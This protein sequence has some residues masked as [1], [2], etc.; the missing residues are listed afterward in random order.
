M[1][2][3]D[4][5]IFI[6]IFFCIIIN[7]YNDIL[8]Y[9]N[10]ISEITLKI[11][12]NG[13]Q[14]ILYT[15]YSRKPDKIYLNGNSII[16]NSKNPYKTIN[17]QGNADQINTIVLIWNNFQGYLDNI[18]KDLSNIIEAD[19]SKLKVSIKIMANSF[20]GC[21]SLKFANISNLDISQ[22]TNMGHLFADCN[23]LISVDLSNLNTLN[24]NY[25]DNMFLN[26][27]SLKSLDLSNFDTSKVNR[28]SNMFKNCTSLISL[29]ISNFYLPSFK[30]ISDMFIDCKNLEYLNIKNIKISQNQ[31][32]TIIKNTG[33]NIVICINENLNINLT[34]LDN[35]ITIDC[36]LNWKE[37]QKKLFV[38]NNSCVDNCLYLYEDKCYN[39]CPYGTISNG[40]ICINN[41]FITETT[42]PYKET[43]IIIKNNNSENIIC[44]VIEFFKG[45]CKINLMTAENKEAFKQSILSAI[46]D[47]SLI[48]LISSQVNNNSH[49]VINDEN[50]IYLIS[51]LSEQMYIENITNINFSECENILKND[52]DN[53]EILY[54]FR[55]DHKI[56]GYNIPIIEYVIFNENGTILN[57]DKCNNIYSQYFIP[58]SIN[59]DNLFKYDT[60]SDYYNDECS[61]YKSENGTDMT[62]YDRKNDY[63]K[64]N[65]SLCEANCTFKGYNSSTSKVECECKTKS[66]LYTIDD[67]SKDDLLN[68]IENE[69]KLTNLNLIKCSN[70]LSSVDNIKNN[71]GFYIISI[72][73]ILFI[74]IMI[75]FCIKGYKNLEKIIDEV[76]SNKFKPERNSNKSRS[77]IKEINLNKNNKK[78]KT[79]TERRKNT[80][81]S[82]SKNSQNS[83]F[84]KNDNNNNESYSKRNKK[85]MSFKVDKNEKNNN[86]ED[87]SMK[88]NDYELNNL[89]Y[90]LALKQDK[91]EFCDYYFSLIKTKQIIFFSFCNFDD[92]NSDII[93]K[94][95]FF[96][97][98]A[99]HYTINA[100]FFT[101]KI[102]HKL[103]VVQGKFDIIYH[104]PFI[105]Y[106]AIIS[107]II[108]RIILTTLVLTEKSI[109]EVKNQMSKLSALKKKKKVL[110]SEK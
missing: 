8:F 82:L 90:E 45:K 66:Y 6:I 24:V 3:I 21:Y 53:N 16:E 83:F 54:I 34:I 42:I 11:K 4:C 32:Q 15:G 69:Q 101:D 36:S 85:L 48:N 57:L 72:I 35:C 84:N 27:F 60:S 97:S 5:I 41:S 39:E 105:A 7:S 43:S 88:F 49:L 33:I 51:S 89:S 17:I 19:L 22:V 99:L 64:N 68:K 2:R 73:I 9:N 37:K 12:G 86:K 29:N 100:L 65:L 98:F 67:L 102:M 1:I 96:L 91:R 107:T 52:S 30:D 76:I 75:I 78:K 23:S 74:I 46:K 44:D 103:Y 70:L 18:F 59:E 71:T 61:Q 47:G 50:E 77:I 92:Y 108:L 106:S 28:I 93:K 110:L 20:Y 56:K 87:D 31:L 81:T 63:N 14:K 104:L 109:L 95:I 38:S 10:Y 40:N 25:M 26:C 55:I 80:L 13:T 94:Y 79:N 62:I 58:V